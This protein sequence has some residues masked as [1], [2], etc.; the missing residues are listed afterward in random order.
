MKN[1]KHMEEQSN[2]QNNRSAV[3]KR[4]ALCVCIIGI[5]ILAGVFVQIKIQTKQQKK[6][7]EELKQT[8]EVQT[9][10]E[11]IQNPQGEPEVTV[12]PEIPEIARNPYSQIFQE[13]EDVVAWIVIPDTKIDLPVV[14]TMEDET[15]YLQRD[16]NQEYNING[17][18][19]MDTD[20]DVIKPSTN[21]IIHG[22]NMKSGEMFGDLDLYQEESYA[23]EHSSIAVFFP[24]C[25]REYEVISVF[26]SQVYNKSDQVFKFYKFFQADTEEEFDSFYKNIKEMSIFDTEMEAEFGDEFLT[27]S[28]CSYQVSNGR[29]VVV[30]KKIK[31]E[32]LLLEEKGE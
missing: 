27:L 4:I 19:L 15:Y 7:T 12:E 32:E 11:T 1:K 20:S 30:A 14:Q 24:N 25:K 16:I 9:I 18:L 6:I 22:H 5:V 31:E 3:L 10:D 8:I 21:L 13:Y 29:F 28:T 23:K 2:K 17:T 26:Y